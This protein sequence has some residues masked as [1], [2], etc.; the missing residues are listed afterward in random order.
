MGSVER[1]VNKRDDGQH[2]KPRSG[3]ALL[4]PLYQASNDSDEWLSVDDVTRDF[5]N[6]G[7]VTWYAPPE[8]LVKNSLW[9]FRIEESLS[10][11]N[12]NPEHDRFFVARGSAPAS[13]R[14]VIDLR[15]DDHPFVSDEVRR[16]VVEEGIWLQFTPSSYAYLWVDDH[17]YVGPIRLVQQDGK[18]R[19]AADQVQ[20]NFIRE[21]TFSE[22]QISELRIEGVPRLFLTSN[23]QMGTIVRSL[24]W[25]SNDVVMKRVLQWMQTTDPAFATTLNLT[26]EA[27]NHAAA[28]ARAG[29][30]DGGGDAGTRTQ[31]LQRALALVSTLE[32]HHVLAQTLAEDL[33]N[34]PSVAAIISE[35][36][37]RERERSRTQIQAELAVEATRLNELHATKAS[38]EEEIRKLE[39]ERNE[40]AA[41]IE[42]QIEEGKAALETALSE[43]LADVMNR[44][45]RTLAR[46]AIIRAALKMDG[47]SPQSSEFSVSSQQNIIAA[48][49]PNRLILPTWHSQSETHIEILQEQQELQQKLS[50]S[51]ETKRI[52]PISAGVLHAAFLSGMMP[53]LSGDAAYDAVDCY[54]SCVAGSRLLWLPVPATTFEP[55]DLLG[56]LNAETL[57]FTPQPSGLLDL[58]LHARNS[59]DLFI[60][61]LDGINRAPIDAYL[62]PILSCYTD[63]WTEEHK[64]RTLS[65]IH[66]G[67][68]DA[69][70]AYYG[71]SRLAWPPNV[72]LAGIWVEGAMTVPTPAAFWNSVAVLPIKQLSTEG[73]Y[74]NGSSDDTTL[75]AASAGVWRGWREAVR[76]G[77]KVPRKLQELFK[78]LT[79]DTLILSERR[80][81]L[82]AEFYAVIREWTKTDVEALH[83]TASFCIAPQMV[84]S[85]N[86][87]LLLKSI[88]QIKGG[89]E[90][91]GKT[92]QMLRLLLS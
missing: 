73:G 15:R 21:F 16:E 31:Q 53:V 23:A 78:L 90:E 27:V 30:A 56:R 89:D 1:I 46:I 81:S 29:E 62:N 43:E 9:Q 91:V 45:A 71:A 63:T 26:R 28:L 13:A 57:R 19:V 79:S 8:G 68:V 18:W 4:R 48:N 33:L 6:R 22:R 44:P 12:E 11:E 61:V 85:G 5:P 25:S 2:T 83:N 32:E 17:V 39:T 72:L 38:L 92:I 70:D 60:V 51:F 69:N 76:T 59:D 36:A 77:A 20:Q 34:L 50:A 35:A 42:R 37:N 47:S 88:E 80:K 84:V 82:C 14:E 55:G 54:A 7:L 58:L 64:R 40:Q 24:D 86:E 67:M 41:T 52:T 87:Q 49:L 75:A 66:P 3:Y 74:Q 10:Y 65:L